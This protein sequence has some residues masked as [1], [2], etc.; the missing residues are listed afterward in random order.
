MLRS[1]VLLAVGARALV[2]GAPRAVRSPLALFSTAD[3]AQSLSDRISGADAVAALFV[4]DGE[5]RRFLRRDKF[6]A[7]VV[8]APLSA[9]TSPAP[10][11]D[12]ALKLWLALGGAPPPLEKPKAKGGFFAS[13]GDSLKQNAL[14]VKDVRPKDKWGDTIVEMTVIDQ[15]AILSSDLG[16]AGFKLAAYVEALESQAAAL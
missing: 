16:K 5:P 1:L 7:S 6:I 15:E 8:G 2:P 11:A 3:D 12:A 9:G 10:S 14:G 4:V 13:F